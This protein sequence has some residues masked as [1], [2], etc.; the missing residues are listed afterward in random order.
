MTDFEIELLDKVT[1]LNDH[2]ILIR[3]AL[4]CIVGIL[5]CMGCFKWR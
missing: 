5:L 2:I 4:W 1:Q 3:G